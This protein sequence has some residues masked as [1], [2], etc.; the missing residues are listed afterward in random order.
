MGMRTKSS[1]KCPYDGILVSKSVVD[2]MAQSSSRY[3]LAQ[4]HRLFRVGVQT[5]FRL[6]R[7]HYELESM[8]DCG[9]FSYVTE[10]EPPYTADEVIDFYEGCGFDYG[11]STR[12][13]HP[14]L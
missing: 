9:A 2:G 7:S 8:G 10:P 11:L 5:F 13:C 14:W 3:S 1:K 6:E 4:R 12:P